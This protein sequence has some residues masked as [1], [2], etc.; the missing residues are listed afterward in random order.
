MKLINLQMSFNILPVSC[1]RFNFMEQSFYWE[2][3][4]SSAGQEIPCILWN[5]EFH[6]RIQNSLLDVRYIV[7]YF[8]T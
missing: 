6:D 4:P 5:P 2:A 7:K 1:T 3:N 8:V